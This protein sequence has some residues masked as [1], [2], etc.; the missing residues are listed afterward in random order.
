ME[1]VK[2]AIAHLEATSILPSAVTTRAIAIAQTTKT[3]FGTTVSKTTLHKPNYLAL[4]HPKYR[5][6]GCVLDQPE[7]VSGNSSESKQA[8]SV[9]SASLIETPEAPN[10]G[11]SQEIPT[12][13]PI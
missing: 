3:L 11:D 5:E 7:R 12:P 9:P 1:R 13:P 10:G 4:W 8:L 2:E 6:K